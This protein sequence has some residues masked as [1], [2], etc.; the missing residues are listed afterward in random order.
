MTFS[1][2]YKFIFYHIPKTAGS[3][4]G[5]AIVEA[6][7]NRTTISTRSEIVN[8]DKL[9]R[10][11]YLPESNQRSIYHDSSQDY[12]HAYYP[13]NRFLS[14]GIL[15]ELNYFSF[16]FVRNPFDRLLSAFKYSQ[17]RLEF[18]GSNANVDEDFQ[19]KNF[20]EFCGEY[21]DSPDFC[22]PV[23]RFNLHYLPQHRFLHDPQEAF[24]GGAP[25]VDFVGRFEN[26]KGDWSLICQTVNMP[27]I[28]LPH[29]RNR[30][31]KS[32]Y[33]DHYSKKSKAIAEKAYETDLNLFNYEF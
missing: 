12:A 27:I 18:E 20:D 10:Y 9:Q 14:E 21:V 25:F 30:G 16:A 28:T 29:I 19:F 17:R 31:D 32:S 11:V 7:P 24:S 26:L 33:R 22:S 4:V 3:S 15:S 23:T 1:R 2:K 8:G 13:M 5:T 6:D